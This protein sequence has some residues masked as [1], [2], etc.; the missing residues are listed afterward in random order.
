MGITFEK[1]NVDECVL[2]GSIGHL[3][4]EHKIKASLIKQE[5]KD[6]HTILAGKDA[7]RRAQSPR[8][9]VFHFSAKICKNCNS[10]ATQPADKAFDDL[11]TSMKHLYGECREL[12]DAA[13]SPN[14]SMSDEEKIDT[15][16]Y[17]A[18]LLCCFLAEVGGPRPK[19][20]A[21]FAIGKSHSN[22]IFL[23][24]SRDD[25]YAAKLA[26]FATQGFAEH[27]GLKFRFDTKKRWVDS[28]ESSL[29]IGGIRYDFW[30]QLKWLAKWELR[31][32]FPKLV[33]TALM[34]IIDG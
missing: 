33:Q 8:S 5:F 27:G 24:I 15:Y 23:R 34:N 18:K 25:E 2:C 30:V 9:G 17:F 22:P 6:R 19:P 14:C 3:T 16:R 29:S 10:V 11:H 21:S 32:F 26:A 7:P 12:T 1:I 28:I 31:F 4:G 20:L 13:H